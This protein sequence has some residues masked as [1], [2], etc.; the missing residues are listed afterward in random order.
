MADPSATPLREAAADLEYEITREWVQNASSMSSG[1]VISTELTASRFC[2]T[3]RENDS[4]RKQGKC[5]ICFK[6]MLQRTIRRHLRTVHG[7]LYQISGSVGHTCRQCRRTFTRKDTL[8]RHIEEKHH[9]KVRVN[10]RKKSERICLEC[11]SQRY[12]NDDDV[13]GRYFQDCRHTHSFTMDPIFHAVRYIIECA[14]PPCN[15]SCGAPGHTETC[16]HL[17]LQ[18]TLSLQVEGVAAVANSLDSMP[19]GDNPRHSLEMFLLAY[20]VSCELAGNMNDPELQFFRRNAETLKSNN[21]FGTHSSTLI[22]AMRILQSQRNTTPELD[23]WI[24][25]I[26]SLRALQSVT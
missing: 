13:P 2:A 25:W 5:P 10:W 16:L 21:T 22:K 8:K 23:W 26:E 6:T 3:Q 14:R 12:S 18:R 7:N 1:Q 4:L 9:R 15:G 11:P 19:K 20:P 24:E 17:K